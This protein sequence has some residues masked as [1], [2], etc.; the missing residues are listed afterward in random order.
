MRVTDASLHAGSILGGNWSLEFK[1][2]GVLGLLHCLSSAK[3]LGDQRFPNSQKRKG[4]S[5]PA[6]MK[7]GW[8][9]FG[10]TLTRVPLKDGGRQDSLSGSL[11][12]L[13]AV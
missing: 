6:T 12:I 11:Q 8:V 1:E 13:A 2:R 7:H 3:S 4:R 10:G 9:L 5:S